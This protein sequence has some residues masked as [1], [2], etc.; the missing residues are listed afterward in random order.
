MSEI[1]TTII[2]PSS[3]ESK[4]KTAILNAI[5]SVIESEGGAA[6]VVFIANG[7]NVD[8]DLLTQIDA[9][10]GVETVLL[11]EPS[12]SNAVKYGVKHY[13]KTP[14]FGFLDDDDYYLP[15]AIAQRQ[16]LL[17][18]S[19]EIDVAVGLALRE[20]DGDLKP[21]LSKSE[22][23]LC[24]DAPFRA[25]LERG[26]NWLTSSAGLYRSSRI[27]NAYFEE[28]TR[29]FEWTYLAVKMMI[30]HV[31]FSFSGV[32]DHVIV[33]SPNSLSKSSDYRRYESVFFEILK[34]LPLTHEQRDCLSIR[35]A[36]YYHSVYD[37]LR[38]SGQRVLALKAHLKS[39]RSWSGFKK[40]ALSTR[41]I[42]C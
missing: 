26:V 42:V 11:K 37:E 22:I 35:E 13:V 25:M 32:T 18:A 27:G 9:L 28:P 23:E 14:F 24:R 8:I 19:P 10:T 38:K 4:N 3:C 21:Q 17:K 20:R 40:Y 36:D 30:D 1:E 29:F 31:S 5:N 7:Q 6:C 2:I 16:A 33:D 12:A 15:G 34:I 39:M 41:K